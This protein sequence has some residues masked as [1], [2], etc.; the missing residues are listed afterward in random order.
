MRKLL[1]VVILALLLLLPGTVS[2]EDLQM[3]F[4]NLVSSHTHISPSFNGFRIETAGFWTVNTPYMVTIFIDSDDLNAASVLNLQENGPF[5]GTFDLIGSGPMGGED[6]T[7]I[8]TD[9]SFSEWWNGNGVTLQIMFSNWNSSHLGSFTPSTHKMSYVINESGDG[10]VLPARRGESADYNSWESEYDIDYA[11]VPVFGGS[12]Y[13]PFTDMTVYYRNSN[14][15]V[16]DAQCGYWEA[17]LSSSTIPRGS[18]ATVNLTEH[19]PDDDFDKI[20]YYQVLPN[21]QKT[22]KEIYVNDPGL[23]GFGDKWVHIDPST[24]IA[25]ESSVA[26]AKTATF[27]FYDTGTNQIVVEIY[28]DKS[29]VRTL[30]SDYEAVCGMVLDVE[31]GEL[32]NQIGISVWEADTGAAITDADIAVQDLTDGSWQNKTA[33]LGFYQYFDVIPGQNIRIYLNEVPWSVYNE[34]ITVPNPPGTYRVLLR[35]PL[36]QIANK[37]WVVF[38]VKRSTDLLP[39]TGV[40]ISLNTTA[41]ATTDSNGGAKFSLDEGATIFYTASKWGYFP[42]TGYLTVTT[43]DMYVLVKL[44]LDPSQPL[45]YITPTATYTM[46]GITTIPTTA[47][48]GTYATLNTTLQRQ[49]ESQALSIWYENLPALSYF[50]LLMILMGGLGMMMD[51]VGGRRK[52]R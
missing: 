2:G 40:K 6:G 31:V 4:E 3:S 45:T 41:N 23:F 11:L 43:D 50:F 35:R 37:S 8:S 15:S 42:Q 51:S 34:T 39:L 9:V 38:S 52:R 22:L 19:D 17:S 30:Y 21:G 26:A 46:P 28:D 29:L 36:E 27:N 16:I 1:L 24:N 7:L 48:P 44:G 32:M 10:F 33:S 13:Q 25:T 5:T 47:G 12:T 18:S 20:L 49:R 14:E